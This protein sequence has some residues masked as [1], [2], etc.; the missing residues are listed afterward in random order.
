VLTGSW[1]DVTLT[2]TLLALQVRRLLG[3]ER[4]L[5]VSCKTPDQALKAAQ[6]G[7]DYVGC[8]AGAWPVASQGLHTASESTS[9]S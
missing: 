7:A 1:P 6:Q 5:G 9:I 8:G 3:P 4:L 2:L